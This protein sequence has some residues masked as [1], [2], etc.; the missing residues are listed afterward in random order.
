[1]EDYERIKSVNNFLK[2]RRQRDLEN[3]LRGVQIGGRLDDVFVNG[4]KRVFLDALRLAMVYDNSKDRPQSIGMNA[5]MFYRLFS[6]IEGVFIFRNGH[7]IL[8]YIK[9]FRKSIR[10]YILRAIE[11]QG[12]RQGELLNKSSVIYFII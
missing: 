4:S 5:D 1:M 12:Y 3:I 11:Y 2:K 10:D 9:L 8:N 7:D 6:D